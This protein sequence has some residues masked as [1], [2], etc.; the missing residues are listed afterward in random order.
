VQQC[1]E[2]LGKAG[3]A[4]P[5]GGALLDVSFVHIAHALQSHRAHAR[6]CARAYHDVR[7]MASRYMLILLAACSRYW[8]IVH[9][10]YAAYYMHPPQCTLH[11]VLQ[12]DHC[13]A[14]WCG[15]RA[16]HSAARE[17]CLHREERVY[18]RHEDVLELLPLG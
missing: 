10:V 1:T 17:T 7:K 12:P 3:V 11:V 14:E 2:L 15:V 16:A 9:V 4:E 5:L 18:V 13:C 6:P 8:C